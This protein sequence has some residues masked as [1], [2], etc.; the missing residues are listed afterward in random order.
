MIILMS[1]IDTLITDHTY[2]NVSLRA[3]GS[4]GVFTGSRLACPPGYPSAH[5]VTGAG[6]DVEA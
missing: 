1:L 4:H 5:V 3:S 2:T 6:I